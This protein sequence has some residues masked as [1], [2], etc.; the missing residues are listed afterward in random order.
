MS[1]ITPAPW[2]ARLTYS[3]S[4]HASVVGAKTKEGFIPFVCH[5]Q[6]ADIDVANTNARLIAQAPEM[7]D[8][9]CWIRQFFIKPES[10]NGVVIQNADGVEISKWIDRVDL[11]KM[12]IG[13]AK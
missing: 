10:G 11:I 9:L 1:Q 2:T 3:R 8:E 5:I 13:G 6:T 12:R 7:L 4:E